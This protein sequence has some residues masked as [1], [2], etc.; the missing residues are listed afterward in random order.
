MGPQT[1][2]LDNVKNVFDL[3]IQCKKKIMGDA[4][5]SLNFPNPIWYVYHLPH[6]YCLICVQSLWI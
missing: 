2:P 4:L 3:T 6:V 5:D 1:W